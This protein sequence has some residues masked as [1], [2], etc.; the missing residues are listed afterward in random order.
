[1]P[2]LKKMIAHDDVEPLSSNFETSQWITLPSPQVKS[3]VEKAIKKVVL[4][5]LQKI[6]KIKI[7][8]NLAQ[9][10]EHVFEESS[11]HRQELDIGLCGGELV[12]QRLHLWGAPLK[13]KIM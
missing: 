1:M 5:Y 7:K 12:S 6:N 10:K 13:P 11:L 9:T 4:L 2:P 8:I 3:P